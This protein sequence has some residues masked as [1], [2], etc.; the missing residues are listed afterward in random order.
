MFVRI[1]WQQARAGRA[2]LGLA[3]ATVASGATVIAALLNLQ[4]GL[5]EKLAPSFRVL[6]TS[7]VIVPADARSSLLDEGAMQAVRRAAE[8]VVAAPYLYL[9]VHVETRGGQQPVVLA[10]TDFQQARLASP[11]WKLEGQWPVSPSQALVG[12]Q[13]ARV[14]GVRQGDG[15]RVS[16]DGRTL[17]LQVS[18]ILSSGSAEDQQVFV[19]LPLVQDLAG[20]PGRL[21]LMQVAWQGAPE[22]LAA[23]MERLRAQLPAGVELRPLPELT[24]AEAALAKKIRW[25]VL[26][27]VALIVALTALGVLAALAALAADRRPQVGVMKAVGGSRQLIF[28][29][30]LTEVLLLASLGVLIGWGLGLPLSDWL[31]RR[32]FQTPAGW[33]WQAFAGMAV[34]MLAAALCGALPLR[35]VGGQSPAEILRGELW[36]L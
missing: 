7:G 32:V 34:A 35:R 13:A 4:V 6:G 25:L 22:Q 18:G 27:T 21:S 33:H 23:G 19:S 16:Y 9:V 36:S 17:R 10:G 20:L 31:S 28:R 1:L 26:A 14:L 11:W 30:F 2:R 29:L 8:P 15:L 24:Q 3:L 12:S 5:G